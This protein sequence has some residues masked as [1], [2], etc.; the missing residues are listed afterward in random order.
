MD[1][2]LCKTI[3]QEEG[4]SEEMQ[5]RQPYHAPK[6]ISLGEIQ[7]IVQTNNGNGTD[8]GGSITCTSS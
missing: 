3:A 5:I 2:K 4:R 7:S 8:G 1:E 6:L